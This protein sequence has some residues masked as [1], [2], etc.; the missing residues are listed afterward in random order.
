VQCGTHFGICEL[1]V[2]SAT[3]VAI[4]TVSFVSELSKFCKQNRGWRARLQR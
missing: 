3:K 4:V 2:N 1:V